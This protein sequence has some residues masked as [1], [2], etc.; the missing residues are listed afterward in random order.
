MPLA[1]NPKAVSRISLEVDADIPVESRPRFHFRFLTGIQQLDLAESMD[2]LDEEEKGHPAMIKV[3]DLVRRHLIGWSNI[4]NGDGNEIRFDKD[5]LVEIINLAEA[6]EILQKLLGQDV[7]FE[8]KKKS[9]S[10]SDSNTARS[11]AAD[12]V[13]EST[14]AKTSQTQ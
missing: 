12:I 9:D 6:N 8:D 14:N 4:R 7:E 13:G 3:F 2:R 10:P 11:V 5:K 1:T